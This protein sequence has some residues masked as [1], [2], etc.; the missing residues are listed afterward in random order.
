MIIHDFCVC[1]SR[2]LW[3]AKT[4]LTEQDIFKLKCRHTGAGIVPYS[5]IMRIGRMSVAVIEIDGDLDAFFA[6]VDGLMPRPNRVI[7]DT[8][9]TSGNK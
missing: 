4:I 8:T 5:V 7:L 2:S 6:I 1:I 9:S 3:E